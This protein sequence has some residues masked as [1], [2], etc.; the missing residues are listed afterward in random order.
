MPRQKKLPKVGDDELHTARALKSEARGAGS[1]GSCRQ[2]HAETRGPHRLAEAQSGR[3]Q[4][5]AS[6][7]H[8]THSGVPHGVASRYLDR[9]K[10]GLLT[11]CIA[12]YMLI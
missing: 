8:K 2:G 4:A 3:T 6:K 7:T 5:A 11:L 1:A 12:T 9:C 10:A